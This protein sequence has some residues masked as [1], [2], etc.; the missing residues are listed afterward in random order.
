MPKFDKK[1]FLDVLEK[2]APKELK[3]RPYEVV[4]E[5][6]NQFGGG[7]FYYEDLSDAIALM[8]KVEKSPSQPKFIYQDI[9]TSEFLLEKITPWV[10]EVRKKIFGSP[11]IP[12]KWNQAIKWLEDKPKKLGKTN[13]K[14][15]DKLKK[16]INKL[17]ELRKELKENHIYFKP[18]KR[19]F[20]PYAKKGDEWIH[21]VIVNN[22][23]LEFL[24][25]ETQ[26]MVQCTGFS[27]ASLV[28]HILSGIKIVV[29]RISISTSTSFRPLSEKETLSNKEITLKIRAKD[30]TFRELLSVYKKIKKEI[31]LEKDK[32][33]NEKQLQVYNFIRELGD[34]PHP[35]EQ[36]RY[37]Y[38]YIAK[39]KWNDKYPKYEYG[40]WQGIR[41]AYERTITALEKTYISKAK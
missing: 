20:L 5:A 23:E 35:G 18:F 10:E 39:N 38:W 8:K 34:P 12:F 15:K 1:G 32:S 36:G 30:F 17:N 27:Q 3:G 41:K 4:S 7:E 29:P 14:D 25:F 6:I 33:L 31:N 22:S 16:L 2:A 13:E 11:K 37:R 9:L 24:E 21:N 28:V 19:R 26:R 40:S